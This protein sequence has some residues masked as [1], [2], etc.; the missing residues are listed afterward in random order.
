MKL[1]NKKKILLGIIIILILILGLY[2]LKNLLGIDVF[3]SYT[4][5]HQFPFDHLQRDNIV[6]PVSGDILIEES[7]SSNDIFQREWS[8]LWMREEGKV[9][10]EYDTNGL[11]HSRCLLIRSGSEKDWAY[12]SL[13]MVKVKEGD[14]FSYQGWVNIQGKDVQAY[15]GITSYDVNKN[16]VDWKC[17]AVDIIA[18][19]L[20][21]K[22]L[23]NSLL[24]AAELVS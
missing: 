1:F 20:N 24:S 17:E 10:Q 22:K 21:F 5:S 12:S 18:E 13:K 14:R 2:W 6:S 16:V 7:F 23:K 4:L 9:V 3:E 11:R 8:N 15:F 19:K